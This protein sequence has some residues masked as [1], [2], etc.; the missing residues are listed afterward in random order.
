MY[1]K[2][3]T[4]SGVPTEQFVPLSDEIRMQILK[5]V[6]LRRNLPGF[7]PQWL[8][9]DARPGEELLRYLTDRRILSVVYH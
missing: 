6:W 4:V 2:W 7:E 3:R 8:F 9:P 5:D 1:Q